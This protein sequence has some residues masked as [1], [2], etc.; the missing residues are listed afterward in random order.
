VL[1][2]P[3]AM[4]IVWDQTWNRW[5]QFL[6][7]KVEIRGTFAEV[8]KY[9]HRGGE[10]QPVKWETALPSR[11]TVKLPASAADDIDTARNASHRSGKSGDAL[12][13]IREQIE[14][15]PLEREALRKMCWEMGIPGDFDIARIT[16]RPDYEEFFYRQLCGRARR[17]YLFREE[18]IFD[19]EAA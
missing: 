3:S 16:W 15:E 8:G 4:P 6:G 10:W 13:R 1:V 14:H 11:L 5:K 2:D 9:R 17:L 7:A 18:Y 19:L 12:A